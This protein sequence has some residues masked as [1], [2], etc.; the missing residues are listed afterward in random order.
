MIELTR[1][2]REWLDEHRVN[3]KLVRG[4]ARMALLAIFLGVFCFNEFYQELP[5]LY[6]NIAIF[7]I[8]LYIA[9]EWFGVAAGTVLHAGM[10]V[11]E[12]L[13][14]A[15]RQI[16]TDQWETPAEDRNQIIKNG[17]GK[18]AG[19]LP[20]YEFNE[21]Y[22]AVFIVIYHCF[23]MALDV[24]LFVALV[25]AGWPITAVVHV[26]GASINYW[27]FHALKKRTIKYV[28]NITPPDEI[29]ENVDELADRLFNGTD[30]IEDE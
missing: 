18:I 10:W 14:V 3:H 24:C 16:E 19:G 4:F 21:G 20:F 1:H 13:H 30:Q 15:V 9:Y 2:Q 6:T 12:S 25:G 29:E 17:Y 5:K 22:C 11:A 7:G 28:K 26:V 27:N 23:D 8:Y